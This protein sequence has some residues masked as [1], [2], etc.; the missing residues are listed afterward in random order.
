MKQS[1]RII[2]NTGMS[3]DEL[4]E[5]VFD[6]WQNRMLSVKNRMKTENERCTIHST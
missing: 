6:L 3:V 5:K 4:I 2:K 1:N